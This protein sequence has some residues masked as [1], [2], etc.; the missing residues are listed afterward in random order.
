MSAEPIIH[1]VQSSE[2][3]D[4]TAS[5]LVAYQGISKFSELV[6]TPTDVLGVWG[7]GNL[8]FIT[9]L[10]LKEKFPDSKVIIFGKH[11]ENLNLFSF[12]DGIYQIHNVPDDLTIDHAF[13]CVGSSASQ[14]ASTELPE[15]DMSDAEFEKY[16]KDQG[17]IS[18]GQYVKSC[19]LRAG[20]EL[21]SEQSKTV[22]LNGPF[23]SVSPFSAV[24]NC[25]LSCIVILFEKRVDPY[26]T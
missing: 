10:L 17:F 20:R 14:S 11:L 23:S 5:L 19:I 12:A 13:E 8:G 1:T 21:R 18:N 3:V 16:M 2:A 22:R 15:A 4:L 7:D 9:S 25:N 6:I 26:V 24:S